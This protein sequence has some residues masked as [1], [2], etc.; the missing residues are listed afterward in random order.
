MRVTLCFNANSE[1][2]FTESILYAIKKL[3]EDSSLDT[4]CPTIDNKDYEMNRGDKITDIMEKWCKIKFDIEDEI[5]LSFKDDDCK[6]NFYTVL[7]KDDY[8][9]FAPFAIHFAINVDKHIKENGT[10][11]KKK[12]Y[13]IEKNCINLYPLYPTNFQLVPYHIAINKTRELL[14]NYM[15]YSDKIMNF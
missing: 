4:V 13:N 7:L 3:S 8:V 6:F 11:S 1:Y 14:K 15:T 5:N 10:I 9:S 12:F 2:T